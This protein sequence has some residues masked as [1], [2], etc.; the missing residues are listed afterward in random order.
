VEDVVISREKRGEKKP[1][2]ESGVWRNLG[3]GST[4]GR[5]YAAW[6]YKHTRPEEEEE[7]CTGEL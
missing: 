5:K 1:S 7:N 2:K 3:G 4:G 6:F